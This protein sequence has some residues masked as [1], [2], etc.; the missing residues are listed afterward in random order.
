MMKKACQA[1]LPSQ[2]T[3]VPQLHNMARYA[4]RFGAPP[5]R[6]WRKVMLDT[7]HHDG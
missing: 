1:N 6:V 7:D 4:T 2:R 5:G 3:E